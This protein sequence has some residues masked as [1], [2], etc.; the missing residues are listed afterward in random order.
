MDTVMYLSILKIYD[1]ISVVMYWNY[2]WR[3]HTSVNRSVTLENVLFE[4]SSGAAKLSNFGFS[5]LTMGG[6]AVEFFVGDRALSAP[7][8]STVICFVIL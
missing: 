6:K 2:F 5:Y 3:G 1:C 4:K 8:V 7:E